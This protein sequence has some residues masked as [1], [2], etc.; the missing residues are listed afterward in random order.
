[1]SDIDI[2]LKLSDGGSIKATTSDSNKLNASLEQ[3]ERLTQKINRAKKAGYRATGGD[4]GEGQ[5]YGVARSAVGTGAAGRDFAKQAQGLGGLV[6]VYATFAANL[7]AV[8]AA[9]NALSNAADTTNMIKGIEQLGVQSGRNLAKLSKDLVSVTDNA[10]SMRE[11]MTVVAQASSAGMSDKNILRLGESA[12]KVS[13]ALGLDLPDAISRLS[14]GI[15]KIEPELLDE[16]GIFV[17]VDTAAAEYARTIGKNATAL[18][19]FERRQAFANAVLDQANKKFGAIEIDANPYA[20][21]LANLKDVLFAGLEL[22]NTVLTPIVGLLA[23]SPTGLALTLAGVASVLLKQAIPAL[24]Q[25]RKGLQ[26]AEERSAKAKKAITEDFEAYQ[27]LARDQARNMLSASAKGLETEAQVAASKVQEIFDKG[28]KI[29]KGK[30][31]DILSKSVA[32]ISPAEIAKLQKQA[33]VFEGISKSEKPGVTD[34]AKQQAREKADELNRLIPLLKDAQAAQQK[35]NLAEAAELAGVAAKTSL[36]ADMLKSIEKSANKKVEIAKIVSHAY[37]DAKLLGFTDALRIL[38][39]RITASSDKLG[40]WGSVVARVKGTLAVTTA[41]IGTFGAAFGNALAG[42]GMLITVLGMLTAAFSSNRREA[43]ASSKALDNLSEA[44]NFYDKVATNIS[45]KDPLQQLSTESIAARTNAMSSMGSAMVESIEAVEKE[46]SK[47]GTVDKITNWFSGIIGK[48]SEGKLTKELSDSTERIIDG[49]RQSQKGKELITDVAGMLGLESTNDTKKFSDAM[50]SANDETK[51]LVATKFDTFLK[52]MNTSAQSAKVLME[53]FTELYKKFDDVVKSAAGESAMNVAS[54][55]AAKDLSEL[56]KVL[57]GEIEPAIDNISKLTRDPKFLRLFPKESIDGVI[58]LSSSFND[59]Q[60]KIADTKL[61]QEAYRNSLNNLDTE[62]AKKAAEAQKAFEGGDIAGASQANKLVQDFKSARERIQSDLNTLNLKDTDLIK[63]FGEL[64][65]KMKALLQQGIELQI[66]RVFA[67]ITTA[68]EKAKINI[69]KGFL[70][71]IQGTQAAVNIGAKLDQKGI[72]LDIKQLEATKNLI[73]AL[74]ENT[75]SLD[76]ANSL[77]LKSDLESKRSATS[78]GSKEYQDL[79]NQISSEIARQ[80]TI[81]DIKSAQ[82]GLGSLTAEQL[83]GI[84][85]TNPDLANKLLPMVSQT[86]GVE[87]AIKTKQG[88]KATIEFNRLLKLNELEQTKITAELNADISS[89]QQKIDAAKA[90]ITDKAALEDALAPLIQEQQLKQYQVEMQ[91]VAWQAV[92]AAQTAQKF[93]EAQGAVEEVM[94]KLALQSKKVLGEKE[95]A[96]TLRQQAAAAGII[97]AKYAN[98]ERTAKLKAESDSLSSTI[99]IQDI[100]NENTRLDL[101]KERGAIDENSYSVAKNTL[102]IRKAEIEAF[103]AIVAFAEKRRSLEA[104]IQA[105]IDKA[106]LGGPDN[107]TE[108]KRLQALQAQQ[109]ANLNTEYAGIVRNNEAKLNATKLTNDMDA[110]T[111]NFAVGLTNAFK[112]MEDAIVEFTKTGKLSFKGMIDSFLEGLLRF[113]IQQMQMQMF[114]GVGGAGGLAKMFMGGFNLSSAA[115]P[116]S[117]AY[118]NTQ[119]SGYANTGAEGLVWAKGGA[120]DSGLQKFAKGGAFTNSVVNSP[121]LFKFAQ[122]AGLMGEAGP[123][124]IMPLKRDNQGNLGVRTDGNQGNVEVVVNNYSNAQA[125]TKE[126]KDSKGNRR[127]EIVVGEMVAQEM[128]RTGSP[129]Q[130][131]MQSTYG[132]KPMVSRR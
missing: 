38:N 91:P 53:T 35:Y 73:V 28:L 75:L 101:L 106:K 126:T 82:G 100:D 74:S 12:R 93:P 42:I 15:T 39:T 80:K 79:T 43:E 21:L 63:K 116:N 37:D 6:H 127:I 3:T 49:A 109:T 1:M 128:T 66:D 23:N 70:Q 44:T 55:E 112:S 84:S 32:E 13:A 65:P 50:S 117:S 86:A 19:E 81:K 30:I 113:E 60:A 47:R 56:S 33:N 107:E 102:A 11:S 95:T 110:R 83:K 76:E 123:E 52:A 72:D 71:G 51:K 87:S 96:E 108:V 88:E 20:K 46:V 68:A 40:K 122:G 105:E 57:D 31:Y 58:E 119:Y 130:Q 69:A 121:T 2:S 16:L 45:K 27:T 62:I 61:T 67:E 26:E 17:R 78:V 98:T 64:A 94:Q 125:T 132:S 85:R 115:N 77:K 59:L 36:H 5:E 111:K 103:S 7:F 22:V 4:N 118:F 120:F 124:A 14:R 131:S 25:F 9:F 97:D 104:S 8:G 54:V 24:S 48:S 18:T 99:L 41:V 114:A 89:I 129:L 29:G 34:A 90:N 10:I 92:A